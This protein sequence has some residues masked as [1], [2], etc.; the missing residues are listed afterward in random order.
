LYILVLDEILGSLQFVNN[1]KERYG[2]G[3]SFF[4]GSLEDAMKTAYTSKPAKDVSYKAFYKTHHNVNKNR[5]INFQR[6]L[7][8]VYLHHDNSVLS[9]VFCGQLL[10]NDNIIKLLNENYIL[11]G[12]DLT[13]ESNKNM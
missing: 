6:K 5:I 11:F 7:L 13:C 4:E 9:N 10:G 2:N 12:W 1:Y 3:P 8:A